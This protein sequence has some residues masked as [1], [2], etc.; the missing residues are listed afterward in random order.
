MIKKIVKKLKV[1]EKKAPTSLK[2]YGNTTS[3]SI[4][5]TIVS[6]CGKEYEEKKLKT[7]ACGFGT[8]LAWASVYFETENIICP[9]V[10][11]Y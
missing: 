4:P 11:I 9:D 2:E 8:G 1:D 5:L 7:L 10:I 6:Q 3:A